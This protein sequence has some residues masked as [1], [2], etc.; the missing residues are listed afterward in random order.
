MFGVCWFSGKPSKLCLHSPQTLRGW[1]ARR[2]L[3]YLSI[4]SISGIEPSH[5]AIVVGGTHFHAVIDMARAH[6]FRV[7]D[8]RT[9]MLLVADNRQ[10]PTV[11]RYVLVRARRIVRTLRAPSLAHFRLRENL[12]AS[13]SS[14][15]FRPA[16]HARYLARSSCALV[17]NSKQI[18]WLSRCAFLRAT[19]AR[20]GARTNRRFRWRAALFM[21]TASWTWKRISS[22]DV[23]SKTTP[24]DDMAMSSNL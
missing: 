18:K 20:R 17:Q 4:V 10:L 7:R 3:S 19:S 12:P 8:I 22:I 13:L 24:R 1:A 2:A 23:D 6:I 16:Q 9:R 14:V 5:W 11:S 21:P 15:N